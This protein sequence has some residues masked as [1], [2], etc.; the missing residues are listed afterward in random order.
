[1]IFGGKLDADVLQVGATL[2][3]EI[4]DDVKDGSAGDSD[5]LGLGTWREL[6]VHPTYRATLDTERDV[7]LGN[8]DVQSMRGEFSLAERAS[9]KPPAVRVTIK[10]D[11]EGAGEPGLGEDHLRD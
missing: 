5:D 2:W 1:V 10:V 3:A 4:H 8:D 9:E 7:G 6:E 11:G